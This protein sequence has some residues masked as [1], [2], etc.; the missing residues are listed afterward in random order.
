MISPLQECFAEPLHDLGEDDARLRGIF[1]P[2]SERGAARNGVTAQFLENAHEYHERYGNLEGFR[3]LMSRLLA[4][5]AGDADTRFILDIGSGSGNTVIPLLDLYPGA[6]VIAT[7]ISPQLLLILREFLEARPQ[8]EGRYGLVCMDVNNDCFRPGAFDLAVGSAIL[9]HLVD[10]RLVLRTCASALVPTG[11]ALFIEPF[12]SG[13][14]VL[15][16]AYRDVLAEAQR[17]GATGPGFEML[18]RMVVDH[19]AR[20]RDKSDPIFS[21]LDDKWYFTRAYFE[22]ATGG[23]EW[24]ECRIEALNSDET[25]IADHA[26]EELRLGIGAPESALPQ[27]AWE[28]IRLHDGFFSREAKRD[29]IFEGA[30]I[31]RRGE[32][33]ALNVP[34]K[35]RSGWWWNPEQSGRGFF[36]DFDAAAPRVACCAYEDEGKPSW[37][38]HDSALLDVPGEG[39]QVGLQ[40]AGATLQLE[41][42]HAAHPG[43]RHTGWWVD[44]QQ[45]DASS[46]IVE[47]LGERVMAAALASDGWSLVVASR[48]RGN[49]FNGEWLRFTGG[50]TLSGPYRAPASSRALGRASLTWTGDGFLVAL[51]PDGTRRI[52]RRLGSDES[53]PQNL[54]STE[55]CAS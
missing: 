35:K 9:H 33:A 27:W 34:G 53:P 39:R 20:L 42:Q 50:Q 13:H 16:I 8:Y 51:L 17:R 21:V 15:R 23:P 6:F 41:A 30:V 32:G 2:E 4:G 18:E 47:H 14:G 48:G 40:L 44:H 45:R 54:R 19:E 52:Y 25:P 43:G 46:I 3:T 37:S 26:R 38:I 49:D 22:D 7:D 28:K 5:I 1:T 29:L 31:L 12:E 24:S 55:K 11:R 36:I 10:P